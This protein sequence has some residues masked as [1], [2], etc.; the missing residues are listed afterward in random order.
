MGCTMTAGGPPEPCG[1]GFP[2]DCLPCRKDPKSLQ[3]QLETEKTSQAALCA[4]DAD[5]N[6]LSS[7]LLFTMLPSCHSK[8]RLP[9]QQQACLCRSHHRSDHL[10][11]AAHAGVFPGAMHL[12]AIP[13]TKHRCMTEA[14]SPRGVFAAGEPGIF[15]GTEVRKDQL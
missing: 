3:E 4:L 14:V 8:A 12:L 7:P 2:F 1:F 5:S 10:V 11:I 9:G 6:G 15:E 13:G